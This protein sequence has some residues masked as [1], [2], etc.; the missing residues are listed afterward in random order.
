MTAKSLWTAALLLTAAA[1]THAQ[2]AFDYQLADH[3]LLRS[4]QVQMDLALNKDQSQGLA[5]LA[6]TSAKATEKA[7]GDKNQIAVLKA[8]D[9]KAMLA[10]LAPN[11]LRRLRE[12]SLQQRG[13]P[14]VA[15][16]LVA[17]RLGLNVS[18]R[19]AI[20]QV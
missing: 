14:M 3:G 11:Q 5:T 8:S 1:T 4:I 12:L 16:P 19:T 13:V 15:S 10:Y 18:Q 2:D 6:A 17:D 7:R 20:H 9:R